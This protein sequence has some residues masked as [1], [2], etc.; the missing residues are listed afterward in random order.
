MD[1][2]IRTKS[3]VKYSNPNL[4]RSRNNITA[5]MTKRDEFSTTINSYHQ[6]H[7]SKMSK[8]SK[9]INK[10]FEKRQTQNHTGRNTSLQSGSMTGFTRSKA[11]K[12][13]L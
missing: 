3:A 8:S 7:V 13:A 2:K 5:D 12:K 4:L 10:F 11:T 1:I 6:E 9:S